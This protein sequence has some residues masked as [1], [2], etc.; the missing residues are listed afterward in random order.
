MPMDG[1]LDFLVKTAPSAATS[2]LAFEASEAACFL[3]W[4]DSSK[5]KLPKS[6][7]NGYSLKMLKT[8]FQLTEG[9]IL[10]RFC[11]SYPKLGMT[12][13]GK[14]STPSHTFP[15][16]ESEYSLLDILERSVA[17][18]YFLSE[19]QTQKLLLNLSG[20][21]KETGST[22]PAESP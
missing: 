22:P 3:N 10:R 2:D 16:T 4:L 1:R 17:E 18:K 19:S 20:E 11:I 21:L 7:P 5:A 8:S 9:A 15:K 14:L 13:N 6:N 12:R